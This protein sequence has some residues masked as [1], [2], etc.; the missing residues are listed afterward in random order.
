MALFPVNGPEV[1]QPL[2]LPPRLAQTSLTRGIVAGVVPAYP[3]AQ[4]NGRPLVNANYPPVQVGNGGLNGWKFNGTTQDL[5][6][7]AF[8]S[9]LTQISYLVYAIQG[10]GSGFSLCT[11]TSSGS[12]GFEILHGPAGVAG[13]VVLRYVGSSGGADGTPV[14]VSQTAPHI[15]IGTLNTQGFLRLYVDRPEPADSLSISGTGGTVSP[16]QNL[17]VARRTGSDLWWAGHVFLAVAWSRELSRS[18]VKALLENPWQIFEDPFASFYFT[19]AAGGAT[20]PTSGALEAQASTLAGTAAHLT[21][22]ATSGTLS[23]QAS[24]VAGTVDHR[25]LHATSGALSAQEATL[26]GTA[27]HGAAHPTSGALA[28]DASTIAGAATHLTLHATSGAL[29]A[30]AAILSGTATHS[31]LH[32]TSGALV[33]DASTVSGT[34]AHTATAHPTSGVLEAGASTV[35]GVA[36]HLTLH[37]TSGILIAQAAT[38]SGLATNGT[39]APAP[40][41]GF[42]DL[43]FDHRPREE[44]KPRFQGL[45][46]ELRQ[47]LENAA[48]PQ[49]PVASPAASYVYKEAREVLKDTRKTALKEPARQLR[50]LELLQQAIVEVRT[51]LE[52]QARAKARR[53]RQQQLLLLED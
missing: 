48:D 27:V 35:S 47:L 39:P 12:Q 30:D 45:R 49:S 32:A 43:S 50:Q 17:Y 1:R 36:A 19:P 29:A 33:A 9:A 11:R 10:S 44:R 51:E 15:Y 24:T 3:N 22:H 38:M 4:I 41:G 8:P 7:G 16:D 40:T 6:L 28:A 46:D 37:T 21:L 52:H 26:A 14:N 18:E 5:N 42:G 20:H 53:R 13:D 34:A 2:A 23:A 25:T 31:V